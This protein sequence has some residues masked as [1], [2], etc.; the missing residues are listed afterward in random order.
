[1][2]ILNLFKRTN[3]SPFLVSNINIWAL[4]N[5]NIFYNKLQ[6]NYINYINLID[7]YKIL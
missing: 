4:F 6:N 2:D 7:N 3:Y 1:M 5:S